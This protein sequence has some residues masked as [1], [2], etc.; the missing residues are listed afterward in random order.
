LLKNVKQI[1]KSFGITLIRLTIY[2]IPINNHGV[3]TDAS[4]DLDRA[5][6]LRDYFSSVA[7]SNLC[8]T[9]M[10]SIITNVDDFKKRL[11]N[12]NVY[13][14]YGPDMLHPRI[15]KDLQNEIALPLKFIY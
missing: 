3:D 12:L 2:L 1:L 7:M 4:N 14:S 15:L 10:D 5:N 9:V 13:N 6:V 8:Y 11:N